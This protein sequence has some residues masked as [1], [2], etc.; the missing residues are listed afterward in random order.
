[1]KTAIFLSLVFYFVSMPVVAQ[2]NKNTEKKAFEKQKKSTIS[3]W[4]TDK[5]K[6]DSIEYY[7]YTKARLVNS[8]K[9]AAQAQKLLQSE[10]K[11]FRKKYIRV[12]I[13]NPQ[14][15][16]KQQVVIPPK[17]LK[18]PSKGLPSRRPVS[19]REKN[20]AI[21]YWQTDKY[22][23]DSIE[24]YNYMKA[25]LI[26]Y[27]RTDSVAESLVRSDFRYFRKTFTRID[28]NKL[29]NNNKK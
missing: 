29:Q 4:K 11:Y 10:F 27:G 8:G 2:Q 25:R 14:N 22:Q 16:I 23:Q 9:T 5:Y 7:N 21:S 20:S 3:Y 26:S 19:D 18:N 13:H 28:Q 1:M 12:D 6:Q 24:Y 17:I 15:K